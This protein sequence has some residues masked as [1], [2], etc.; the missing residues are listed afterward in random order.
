MNN[1]DE[2]RYDDIINLPHHVS[3]T[4][5]HMDRANRAA[6]FSPFAALNGYEDAIEETARLTD[7]KPELSDERKARLDEKM[8]VLLHHIGERPEVVVTYFVPDLRK[9]GGSYEIISG[10]V[11]KFDEYEQAIVFT[12]GRKVNISDIFR[13]ESEIYKAF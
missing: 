5:P 11:R 13:I 4:H 8:Q 10:A 6:Q 1:S 3:F 7:S 2:R 9:E 12:D